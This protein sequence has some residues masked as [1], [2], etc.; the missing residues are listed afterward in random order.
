MDKEE[1][2]EEEE[3]EEEEESVFELVLRG[4]RMYVIK[5]NKLVNKMTM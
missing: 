2:E 5:M 4:I 3:E 1:Q